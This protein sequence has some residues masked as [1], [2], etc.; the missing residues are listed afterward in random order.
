MLSG[1]FEEW[2]RKLDKQ[3][4]RKGRKVIMLVDNCPAHPKVADLKSIN[5]CFLPPNTT[6]CLQ[7]MDQGIIQNLKVLYRRQVVERILQSIDT[8]KPADSSITVL[9]AIRMLHNA[10]HQVTAETIENCF[11]HAG[12]MPLTDRP[13]DGDSEVQADA[14]TAGTS[15]DPGNI[16]DRLETAFHLEG[17]LQPTPIAT[18]LKA[19]TSSGN[20]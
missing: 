17:G 13:T 20:I 6:S 8:G 1:I 19:S 2:L 7:P 12:F 11:R 5:L 18:G 3:F 9:D 16:W 15:S 14:A 10:W 4:T